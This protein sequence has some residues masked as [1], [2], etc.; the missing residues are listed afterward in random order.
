MTLDDLEEQCGTVLHRLGEDLEQIAVFV[1]VHEDAKLANLLE[2]L[3][4]LPHASCQGV[5][6][7]I[8]YA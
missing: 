5:V 2:V 1:A 6:V 4:D 3:V 8:R 7:G